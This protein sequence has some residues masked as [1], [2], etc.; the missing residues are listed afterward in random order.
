VKS[1]FLQSI[2]QVDIESQGVLKDLPLSAIQKYLPGILPFESKDVNVP[3]EVTND[4]YYLQYT[5]L[6][7][8]S[9]ENNFL[10]AHD[11]D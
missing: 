7:L 11:N 3:F 1:L 2:K 4:I 9:K 6:K 5:E 10:K 8:A